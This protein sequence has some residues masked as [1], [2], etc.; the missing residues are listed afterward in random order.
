MVAEI[1]RVTGDPLSRDRI[2]KTLLLRDRIEFSERTPKLDIFR[3]LGPIRLCGTLHVAYQTPS[4]VVGDYM[5]CALFNAHMLLAVPLEDGRRFSIVVC[6]HLAQLRIEPS[7][8]RR[9]K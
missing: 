8:N 2:R 1:N 3:D 4:N 7:D 6:F 5:M 9:G